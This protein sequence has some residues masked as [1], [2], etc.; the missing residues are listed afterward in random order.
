MSGTS[1]EVISA[2]NPVN[3]T[4]VISASGSTYSLVVQL[5]GIGIRSVTNEF[6][7]MPSSVTVNVTS[8]SV[9]A[10]Y[11]LTATGD[12]SWTTASASSLSGVF[13]VTDP[14]EE[15][16]TFDINLTNGLTIVAGDP[17]LNQPDGLHPTA[18]GVDE[19]V[20]RILP[21]VEQLVSRVRNNRPI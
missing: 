12:G 18:A 11:Y 8:A 14:D 2:T 6:S 7:G 20:T 9:P 19:I 1:D 21:Q 4:A 10:G 17:K 5:G 15:S 3:L 13:T 16:F